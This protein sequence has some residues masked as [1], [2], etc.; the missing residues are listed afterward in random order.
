MVLVVLWAGFVAAGYLV[1][2][3]KGRGTTG[4]ALGMCFGIIGVAAVAWLRPQPGYGPHDRAAGHTR[5]GPRARRSR[6]AGS[7]WSP[8]GQWAPDPHRRHQMRWWSGAK[9]TDQVSDGETAFRDPL[10]TAPTPEAPAVIGWQS[11]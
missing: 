3:A 8:V 2:R 6:P 9:W 7:A 10:C 5:V 1:G 11:W 4:A